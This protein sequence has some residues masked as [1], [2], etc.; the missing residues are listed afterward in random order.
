[1]VDNAANLAIFDKH[2]AARAWEEVFNC[3]TGLLG[4]EPGVFD[5]VSEPLHVIARFIADPGYPDE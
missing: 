5:L 2:E 4:H 3:L 1:M